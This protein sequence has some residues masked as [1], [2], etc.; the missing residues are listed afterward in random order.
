MGGENSCPHK[1]CLGDLQLELSAAGET[2]A[3]TTQS[4][5]LSLAA[6]ALACW[7]GTALAGHVG[8][9]LGVTALCASAIAYIASGIGWGRQ[10]QRQNIF[11]GAFWP[12][13]FEHAH[14]HVVCRSNHNA[15][16]A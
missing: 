14:M 13:R 16:T 15:V 6:A 3:I 8:C 5:A 4:I 1:H 9:S 7:A 10:G 2:S 12:S 11:A